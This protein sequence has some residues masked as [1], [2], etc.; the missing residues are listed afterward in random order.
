MDPHASHL[1]SAAGRFSWQP[2]TVAYRGPS[3]TVNICVHS[4]NKPFL[5]L[6]APALGLQAMECKVRSW[7]LLS[8]I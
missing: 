4:F 6:W 5:H 8:Y 2:G 7:S 1:L 3:F